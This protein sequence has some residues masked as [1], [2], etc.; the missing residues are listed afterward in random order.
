MKNRQLKNLAGTVCF[1]MAT[2]SQASPLEDLFKFPQLPKPRSDWNF[3]LTH[4]NPDGMI[5]FEIHGN[6]GILVSDDIAQK[7]LENTIRKWAIDQKLSVTSIDLDG[8]CEKAERKIKIDKITFTSKPDD[9]PS[10]QPSEDLSY[11]I[12]KTAKNHYYVAQSEMQTEVH[13]TDGSCQTP[14]SISN[15]N[16]LMKTHNGQRYSKTCNNTSYCEITQKEVGIGVDRYDCSTAATN[17]KGLRGAIADS[18][19]F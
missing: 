19:C 1:L 2:V 4:G 12:T 13:V 5:S 11:C 15:I 8:S 18:N 7:A 16:V 17:N 14:K 10:P 9:K 6:F 3:C